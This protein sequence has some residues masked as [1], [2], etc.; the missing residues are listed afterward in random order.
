MSINLNGFEG[1][2][3][4]DLLVVVLDS[5]GR[6]IFINKGME[7]FTGRSFKELKGIEVWDLFAVE[8][9]GNSL[10]EHFTNFNS[11]LFPK[12]LK[13]TML[14]KEGEDKDVKW[15]NNIL[16]NRDDQIDRVICFGKI[17]SE[18]DEYEYEDTYKTE[19]VKENPD[20]TTAHK[21]CFIITN[22]KGRILDISDSYCELT[23]YSRQELLK[24]SMHDMDG[25]TN[26][27]D[28]HIN[29]KKTINKGHNDFHFTQRLNND[30]LFELKVNANYSHNFG[31]LIFFSIN[32]LEKTE[33]PPVDQNKPEFRQYLRAQIL[34]KIEELV[35]IHDFNGNLIYVNEMA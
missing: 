22:D 18:D 7:Q 6:I 3:N 8:E 35:F 10:K 15:T 1:D 32:N 4:K 27:S 14:V 2:Q 29:I 11:E 26:S 31:G 21:N 33:Q 25:S 24:L 17:L 20:K 34:D 9:E 5:Q 30:E 28:L 19:V 13:G 12:K 16:L 23:G